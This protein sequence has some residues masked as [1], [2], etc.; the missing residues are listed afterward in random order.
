[1]NGKV[2]ASSTSLEKSEALA[3][4]VEAPFA[5]TADRIEALYM[6]TLSRRPTSKETA[7]VEKF[8]QTAATRA[9]V[10]DSKTRSKSYN[11]ALAD[12]FWALLN[13]PEFGLNH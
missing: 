7:R 5:T 6:A 11:N 10:K 2:T 4:I 12:V 8:I 13:S 9:S 3:A 1:M